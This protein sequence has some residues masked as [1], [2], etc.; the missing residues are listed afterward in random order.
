MLRDEW[1]RRQGTGDRILNKMTLRTESRI[2][3]LIQMACALEVCA[4]KPGNVNR[5]HDF[6]DA[7][8]EDFLLSA[9]AIGPSFENAARSGVGQII[10]DAVQSTRRW[11]R[12][13]TNLGMILLFAPLAKACAGVTAA[14][15]IRQELILVLNSLTVEDARLA[16]D[17]IRLANPGGLGSVARADVS[18]EPSIT[19]LEAMRLAQERDSIAR[20]YVTGYEI[21]FEI[22]LPALG[23]AYAQ[24][25]NYSDAIV[26][27]FLTIISRVPDTLIVRKNGEEAAR[28]VSQMAIDVLNKGGI[29]SFEGRAALGSMDKALRDKTHRLNP[30]TTADITAAALFLTLLE[31]LH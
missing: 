22:G 5:C 21:T 29:Y 10:L 16:Y 8:L 2:S 26:Q 20:E 9:I 17:A 1:I 7:R 15:N 19:L 14:A 6:S 28:Q 23:E 11:V 31:A 18:D 27:S 13:N 12:S 25:G 4:P 3:Q 24:A 30:G